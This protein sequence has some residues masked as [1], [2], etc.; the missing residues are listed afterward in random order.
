M[1]RKRRSLTDGEL[2][3][4]PAGLP[5]LVRILSVVLGSALLVW[6]IPRLS[7]WQ[8]AFYSRQTGWV[9]LSG[10]YVSSPVA[11]SSSHGK[12]P[13]MRSRGQ[14]VVWRRSDVELRLYGRD[15]TLVYARL[16]H[17]GGI[18]RDAAIR[19]YE[20]IPATGHYWAEL[21]EVGFPHPL[22]RSGLFSVSAGQVV[23]VEFG[24]GGFRIR[25]Q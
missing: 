7:H 5:Q 17:P 21:R 2:V 9:V 11:V 19:F 14:G 20:E 24:N 15:S 16:L 4:A 22:Y 1:R 8:S 3:Q 18:R 13:H 6:A 23:L 25:R 12:L 10:V